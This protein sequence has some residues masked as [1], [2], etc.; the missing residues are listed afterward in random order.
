MSPLEK[1]L[2][3][4]LEWLRIAEDAKEGCTIMEIDEIDNRA[5]DVTKECKLGYE[6]YWRSCTFRVVNQYWVNLKHLKVVAD[7]NKPQD[8]ENND[9]VP[10]VAV[11]YNSKNL[12]LKE[13]KFNRIDLAIEYHD[14]VVTITKLLIENPGAILEWHYGTQWLPVC[15]GHLLQGCSDECVSL[16]IPSP[17]WI[18]TYAKRK[19]VSYAVKQSQHV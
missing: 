12:Y 2:K 6:S 8:W 10:F 9:T 15:I 1:I 13:N 16:R 11:L 3:Y 14:E 17:T 4:H 5:V 7:K 18:R 19:T